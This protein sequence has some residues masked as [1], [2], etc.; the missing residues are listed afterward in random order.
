MCTPGHPLHQN[1]SE[2][3]PAI[4]LR[5]R[6]PFPYNA[7][8]ERACNVEQRAVLIMRDNKQ[9]LSVH[10]TLRGRI[11]LKMDDTAGKEQE[12][13]NLIKSIMTALAPNISKPTLICIK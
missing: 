12:Q 6:G 13:E 4:S 3:Y 9:T 5:T 8:S 11:T 10:C 2:Y 1:I 7:V